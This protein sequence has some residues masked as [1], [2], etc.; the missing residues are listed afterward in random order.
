MPQE[1]G[2]SCQTLDHHVQLGK[3]GGGGGGCLNSLE[4]ALNIT[5]Y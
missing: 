4:A 2:T 1:A 5:L 3:G